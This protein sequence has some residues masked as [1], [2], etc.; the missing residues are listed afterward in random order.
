M[1]RLHIAGA[2]IATVVLSAFVC[3]GC[4]QPPTCRLHLVELPDLSAS[5][6]PRSEEDALKAMG[7]AAAGMQRGDSVAVIPI[8]ADADNDDQ[9]R[10]LRWTLSTMREP[11]DGDLLRLARE[12]R[13]ELQLLLDQTLNH[14]YRSTDILGSLHLAEQEFSSDP[15]TTVKAIAILSDLIEDDPQ[16]HF[17]RDRRLKSENTARQFALS[18]SRGFKELAGV[19]VYLGGL[20]SR[21]LKTLPQKRREAIRTF[22]ATLLTAQGARVEWAA[23]G[24]GRL[25]DFLRRCRGDGGQRAHQRS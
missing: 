20:A 13:G 7:K 21:D 2:F 22:W 17:A 24:P 14:P 9:R 3:S 18:L 25:D 12:E 10:I 16:Y 1:T 19:T 8:A 23:D 11:F 15:S 4:E 5:I 6:E